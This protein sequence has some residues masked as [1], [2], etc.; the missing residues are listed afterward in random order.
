MTSLI[1][2]H[3]IYSTE[4]SLALTGISQRPN[5]LARL[6]GFADLISHELFDSPNSWYVNLIE[7][8]SKLESLHLDVFPNDH[9]NALKNLFQIDSKLTGLR[10]DLIGSRQS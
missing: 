5:P 8:Y 2:D 4:Q 6:V 7:I 10:A 1:E 9:W 3:H